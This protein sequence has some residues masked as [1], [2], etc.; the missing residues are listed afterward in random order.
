MTDRPPL[1]QTASLPP[2]SSSRGVLIALIVLGFIAAG[3]VAALFYSAR[4]I[5]R[6]VSVRE[7]RTAAGSEQVTIRTPVGNL[8]VNQRA[9]V[10]PALIGLPVYPGARR[11]LGKDSTRMNLDLPGRQAVDLAT[12]QFE[13]PDPIERVE[14][15]YREQLKG[16]ITKT[17]TGEF[18][19]KVIFEI[20]RDRMERV[21]SLKTSGSGTAITLVRGRHGAA[22]AN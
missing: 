3:A 18:G 8:E 9:Q 14:S 5:S 12:A 16:Q 7:H 17:T 15:Y 19:Q 22:G 2:R 6:A 1:Q 4:I 13:T 20:K 10:D 11:V 21:V